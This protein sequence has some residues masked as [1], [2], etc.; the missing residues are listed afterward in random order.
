M[1]HQVCK[2]FM[3]FCDDVKITELIISDKTE[4]VKGYWFHTKK[5][6]NYKDAID[7]KSFTAYRSTFRLEKFLKSLHFKGSYSDYVQ[8]NLNSLTQLQQLKIDMEDEGGREAY[9][10][11]MHLQNLEILELG[12]SDG[13][14]FYL[15]APNL[16]MLKC[17]DFE[18]IQL[19]DWS[20]INHLETV[21][22]HERVQLLKNLQ[23]FQVEYNFPK[24]EDDRNILSSFPKLTTLACNV[25][26]D[27]F[28][29]EH[30]FTLDTLRHFVNQKRTLKRADLK[31][32]FNSVE[33][34]D[35]GKIDDILTTQSDLAFQLNHYDSLSDNIVFDGPINYHELMSWMDGKLPDNF[36]KKYFNIT[37]V[38]VSDEVASQG[39]LVAFLKNLTFLNTLYLEHT[40][41]DQS[42]YDGLYEI[43]QLTILHIDKSSMPINYDFLFKLKVLESFSTDYDS[44]DFFDLA[45]ELH[46]RL[47]YFWAI[48]FYFAM[49]FFSISTCD[50][51]DGYELQCYED[52]PNGSRNLLIEKRHLNFDQL[53][54]F[55]DEFRTTPMQF[56]T[57]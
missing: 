39:H 41:F 2:R 56:S 52:T 18:P 23:Y 37:V 51:H 42:F 32:Y 43:G 54:R 36:F 12:Y 46:K 53:V 45:L 7:V 57:R 27:D 11:H 19:S 55:I 4:N 5:Q 21:F 15:T 47:K 35:I 31:I 16:K 48:G 10:H 25:F 26:M 30:T 40:S 34:N 44:P 3:L 49:Q 22:Q 9:N 14:Q 29:D 13:H 28:E 20:T 33:L 1:H 17:Y 8:L 50:G 24:N 6:F 38:E